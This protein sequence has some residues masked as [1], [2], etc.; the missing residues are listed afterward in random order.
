MSADL[1]YTVG[2]IRNLLFD[3]TKMAATE[4]DLYFLVRGDVGQRTTIYA[5]E[6]DLMP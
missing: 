3:T 1:A 2:H 6:A 5:V 4:T